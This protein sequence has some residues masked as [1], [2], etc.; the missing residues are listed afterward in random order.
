MAA[1]DRLDLA[2]NTLIIFTSDNGSIAKDGNSEDLSGKPM[3]V[4]ARFGH[5][6]NRPWRGRKGNIY[7][8]GHRVPFIARWPGHI[9]PDTTSDETICLTDMMATFAAITGYELPHDAGED[10]YNILP[11]LLG[12][13]YEGTLRPATVHHSGNGVFAIRQGKWKLI[14]GRGAD[15]DYGTTLAPGEP[16]QL[17]DMQTDPGEQYN[18]YEQRPEIVKPLSDLLEQYKQTGRSRP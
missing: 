7:E 2:D 16:G 15:M 1:L 9:K 11:A 10:S 6:S 8:G 13:P 5:D 18:Q 12:E 17:Y 3:S 4:K 14:E